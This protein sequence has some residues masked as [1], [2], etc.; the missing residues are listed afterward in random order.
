MWWAACDFFVILVHHLVV[1]FS[2][3]TF[4]VFTELQQFSSSPLRMVELHTMSL[5]KSRGW[6][7][8]SFPSLQ[9]SAYFYPKE[10]VRAVFN[11]PPR[12]TVRVLIDRHSS[13][14]KDVDIHCP[15]NPKC[16]F[17]WASVGYLWSGEQ[18]RWER[19]TFHFSYC[20]PTPSPKSTP[21]KW[22]KKTFDLIVFSKCFVSCFGFFMSRCSKFLTKKAA[23]NCIEY[24]IS[25][26][27]VSLTL[28]NHYFCN[29]SS[30]LKM[31]NESTS[32]MAKKKMAQL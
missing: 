32:K 24:K 9:Q 29:T 6:D 22:K 3:M 27:N 15:M 5:C 12:L 18:L 31:P 17:F 7:S 26:E 23:L 13:W 2:T 20:S 8:F 16:D 10:L 30:L 21:K 19:G 11:F 4:S 1:T 25:T 28:T 14:L